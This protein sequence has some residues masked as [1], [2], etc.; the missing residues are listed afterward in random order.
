MINFFRKI[1]K[2]LA[3]DNKPLKYLRYAVGEIALII[4]GI[5]LALSLNNWSVERDKNETFE[6][7]LTQMYTNLYCD[8]AWNE[9][10]LLGLK[11]QKAKATEE[12]NEAADKLV[13]LEIPYT[14]I[15]LNSEY[16]NYKTNSQHVLNQLQENMNSIEQN[17]LVNQINHYFATWEEW[18][19][20][21]KKK[22]VKFLNGLLKKYDFPY[23]GGFD[24]LNESSEM[25]IVNFTAEEIIKAK[26]IRKDREYKTQIHSTINKIDELIY[27]IEYKLNETKA[28]LEYFDKKEHPLKLNFS[29][30]GIIGSALPDG[31]ERSIPMKLVDKDK[32]IW[33]IKI[34]VEDGEIK[35]RNGNSWSQNWGGTELFDGNVLFFGTHIPIKKGH[36]EIE[37]NIVDKKYRITTIA[38]TSND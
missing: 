16:V 19:S 8:Y 31:W 7:A 35:F 26:E 10:V 14:I 37:L 33:K 25:N 23:H 34:E 27:R 18:D 21:T 6:S 28:L 22:Q 3:D 1:R 15:Y 24:L 11:K 20:D 17:I 32:A 5:L 13:G 38:G 36:Y 9:F 29:N 30:V 12:L 4:L 2:Q